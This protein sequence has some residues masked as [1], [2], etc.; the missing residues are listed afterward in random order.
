MSKIFGGSKSEQSSTSTSVSQ[1]SSTNR[2]F[3]FLRDA[4]TPT[5]NTGNQALSSLQAL[6]G[7]DSTGFNIYKD[8]TGFD[9]AQEKGAKGLFNQRAAGR[10][11]QSGAAGRALVDYGN[12]LEQ[13]YADNYM[14]RLLGMAG[15]GLNAGQIVGGAGQTSSSTGNAS[16]SSYGKSSSSPGIA[17]FLGGIMASDRRAKTNIKRIGETSEGL[18]LYEFEYIWDKGQVRTGVMADE[19]A[20]IKPEALGPVIGG[21][22]TVDYSKLELA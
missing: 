5:I 2:A 9:F 13:T 3:D 1:S 15:I 16:S 17:G 8:A 7:G 11:L 22:Q 4:Y 12:R 19:V 18:G 14:N 10:V 6:L 20:K 21:Y